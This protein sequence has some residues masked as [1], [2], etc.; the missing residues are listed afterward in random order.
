MAELSM[1]VMPVRL[2]MGRVWV[3]RTRSSTSCS[4][5]RQSGP[6]WMLPRKVSTAMPSWSC[7]LVI[8]RITVLSPSEREIWIGSQSGAGCLRRDRGLL[9]FIRKLANQAHAIH[10]G[11]E[12]GVA[13]AAG[14]ERR[15]PLIHGLVRFGEEAQPLAWRRCREFFDGDAEGNVAPG[16]ALHDR[17]KVEL[18]ELLRRIFLGKLPIVHPSI[19]RVG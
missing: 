1:C 9:T 8:S 17:K 2:K 16:L 15:G 13:P 19:P 5:R 3:P 7:P 14:H 4:T 10:Q 11:I 12:D 6:V 18:G